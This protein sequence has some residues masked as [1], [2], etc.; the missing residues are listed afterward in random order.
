[1]K[2]STIV[3]GGTVLGILALALLKPRRSIPRGAVAVKPF[4]IKKYLGKWYE[5][6]RLDFR[7]EK[8]L[9]NTTAHYSLNSDS[10]VK[11]TNR[12]YNYKTREW[13][14]SVGKARFVSSPDEGRLKVSFFR[15]FYSGYN[16]LAIDPGY[17]YALI[18]GK[19]LKYL[20]LLSRETSLPPN[21]KEDYLS[22]AGKLGFHTE[23]L[24]WV[25]HDQ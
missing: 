5:I 15:P 14:E 17:K 12:G 1:M 19:N 10:F 4:D 2:K 13:K 23:K 6:A 9:N 22:L 11:V 24:V 3:T 20:W 25:E 16:V 18:A 8:D 21:I 7:F